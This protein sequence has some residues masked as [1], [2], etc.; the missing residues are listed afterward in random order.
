MPISK[1]QS[2]IFTNGRV[3]YAIYAMMVLVNIWTI[4]FFFSNLL[5]CIPISVN[6]TGWGAAFDSCINTNAVFLA[7]AWSDEVTDG[8]RHPLTIEETRFTYPKHSHDPRYSLT[9]RMYLPVP[10]R[11]IHGDFRRSG[12]FKCRRHGR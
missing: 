1:V 7:Q 2:S 4:A 6:W 12:G 11:I 3:V 10:L 5:Q 9:M 8:N